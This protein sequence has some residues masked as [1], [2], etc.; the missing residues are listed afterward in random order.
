MNTT[1][2]TLAI[3]LVLAIVVSIGGTLLTL[4]QLQKATGGTG[5]V[6]AGKVDLTVD[7][8]ASVITLFNVSF[9]TGTISST[10]YLTTETDLSALGFTACDSGDTCGGLVLEND[11][12]VNINVTMYSDVTAATFIGGTSPAYKYT[13]ANG[14]NSGAASDAAGAEPGCV[15]STGVAHFMDAVY[16]AVPQGSGNAEL[17]CANFTFADANDV[18]RVEFN[19][20]IPDDAPTGAKT[21]ALTFTVT[22][23]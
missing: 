21:S 13:M 11:G 5:K 18:I 16:A 6:T 1:N 15:N 20:T 23:I 14:T 4:N 9:G 3:F 8:Q 17:I 19:I 10:T 22:Q 2:K 7:P 12:N